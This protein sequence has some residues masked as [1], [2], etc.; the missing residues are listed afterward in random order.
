LNL[1]NCLLSIFGY[2]LH[3]LDDKILVHNGVWRE[4]EDL[5]LVGEQIQWHDIRLKKLNQHVYV[6]FLMWSAPQGEAKVQNLIWYVY[7]L[8]E[9][10]MHKVSEQVVQRRNPNFGEGGPTYFF[11]NM[12]SHGI[13]SKNGKTYLSYK[14]K[15]KQL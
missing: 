14:G 9:S 15:D 8:N 3:F 10:Q 6:E 11:D 5:P 1:K 4:I 2:R 13:K 7:Q 12:I